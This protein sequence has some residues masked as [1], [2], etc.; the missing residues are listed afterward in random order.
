MVSSIMMKQME[1]KLIKMKIIMM[2]IIMRSNIMQLIC[3]FL[4]ISTL[5]SLILI[6]LIFRKT[7]PQRLIS[8]TLQKIPM[9]ISIGMMYQ[10]FK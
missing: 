6:L 8:M 3:M 2:K 9:T 1:M 10:K 5:G 4:L 7:S